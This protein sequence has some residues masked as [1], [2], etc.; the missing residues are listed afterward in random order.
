MAWRRAL[1]HPCPLAIFVLT[2][3]V[4]FFPGYLLHIL[5]TSWSYER[6]ENNVAVVDRFIAINDNQT[7]NQV[8]TWSRIATP[9]LDQDSN[10]G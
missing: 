8:A 10:F 7:A 1:P 6:I 5:I 4:H 9:R 3:V 2:G